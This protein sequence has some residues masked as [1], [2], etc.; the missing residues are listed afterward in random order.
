MLRWPFGFNIIRILTPGVYD[1]SC[2]TLGDSSQVWCGV[3]V[4]G[5]LKHGFSQK[6]E[7]IAET[8]SRKKCKCTKWF[9]YWRL[10]L[11]EIN[12]KRLCV[13]LI[14]TNLGLSKFWHHL[15]TGKVGRLGSQLDRPTP[16]VQKHLLYFKFVFFVLVLLCRLCFNYIVIVF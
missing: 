9:L 3:Q 16:L 5:A 1:H 6:Q 10:I 8:V 4:P 14:L 7:H 2:A 11:L 12:L 15:W 13:V